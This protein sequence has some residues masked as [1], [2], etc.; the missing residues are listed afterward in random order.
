MARFYGT[1]QGNRGEATRLGHA[2][3]G[4]RVSAQ[5]YS[6]SIIIRL[7]DKDGEDWVT[8]GVAPSSSRQAAK[9]LYTG[10]IEQLV[11]SSQ[12]ATLI[13]MLTLNITEPD[14]GIA[15]G[16]AYYR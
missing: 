16:P 13:T 10:P 6:G 11:N 7:F 8:I 15:D 12:R 1:V 2:S 5:S 3:R 14:D 9:D 4:L